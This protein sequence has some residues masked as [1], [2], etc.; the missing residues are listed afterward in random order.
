[1]CVW[2]LSQG[3]A[4]SPSLRSPC[5]WTLDCVEVA[6]QDG[7]QPTCIF[8]AAPSP[9]TSAAASPSTP[10]EPTAEP[11]P[12]TPVTLSSGSDA[13]TLPKSRPMAEYRVEVVTADAADSAFD[14]DVY[15]TLTV[16][17]GQTWGRGIDGKSRQRP[18]NHQTND[19]CLLDLTEQNTHAAKHYTE[20]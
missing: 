18:T 16:S 7:S 9:I 12:S 6:R 17:E 3:D 4:P 19:I 10:A 8:K 20:A 2:S 14:G 13:V 5:S 11:T 1:M 15:L